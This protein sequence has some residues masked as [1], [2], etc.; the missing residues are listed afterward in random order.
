MNTINETRACPKCGAPCDRDSVHNGIA[1]LYGPWG[2]YECGWSEDGDYDVS[3]G[4]KFTDDGYRID[5][6]GGA[7]P[8]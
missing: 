7:T 5:Q 1:M 8:S 4:P 6:F 3:A 2:C